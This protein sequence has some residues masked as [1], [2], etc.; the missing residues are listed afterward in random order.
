MTGKQTE[1]VKSVGKAFDIVESLRKTGGAGVSELAGHVDLP[2]STVHNHLKTLEDHRYVVRDGDTY[3]LA[4]RFIHLGDDVKHQMDLYRAGE[5]ILRELADDTGESVNLV[6]E[7]YGRGIYVHCITGDTGLR[8][9]SY[10]RRREYL[11]STAAGKAILAA[12]PADRVGEIVESTGLPAR[13]E[14]TITDE[15]TLEDELEEC[16]DRG[17]AFN[18]EEN[19]EGIRAVGA[20]IEIGRGDVAALSISGPISRLEGDVFHEDHRAQVRSA[21]KSIEVELV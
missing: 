19:T 1:R 16:R 20:P 9:Y 5:R 3:R 7:E 18:D 6:V 11:H 12:L 13:T 21:A 10:I 14:N 15:G 8:N 2:V 4:G 17:V